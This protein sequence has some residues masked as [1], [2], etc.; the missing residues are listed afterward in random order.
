MKSKITAHLPTAVT[1]S[2]RGTQNSIKVDVKLYNVKKGS[3][4]IG[5]GGIEWWPDYNKVNAHRASWR[6]LINLLEDNIPRR[7]STR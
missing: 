3:L 6:I 5:Q 1:L 7:R 4:Y 2:K